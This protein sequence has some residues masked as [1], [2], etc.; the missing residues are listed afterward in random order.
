MHA[1]PNPA[2][3]SICVFFDEK[4][5]VPLS[6]SLLN[7]QGNLLHQF[8]NASVTSDRRGFCMAL[9]YLPAGEYL[10]VSKGTAEKLVKKILIS[11]EP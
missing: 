11:H 3:K 10:L 1:Y 9:P 7:M 6:F 5:F 2:G 4:S 8:D